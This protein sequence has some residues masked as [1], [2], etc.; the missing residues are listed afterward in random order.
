MNHVEVEGIGRRTSASLPSIPN[1]TSNGRYTLQH[2]PR[3]SLLLLLLPAGFVSA[4]SGCR[5]RGLCCGLSHPRSPK[6]VQ[7]ESTEDNTHSDAK[8]LGSRRV[9]AWTAY[10]YR[11]SA[12]GHT[13]NRLNISE[14]STLGLTS[15]GQLCACRLAYSRGMRS[16]NNNGSHTSAN[17]RSVLLMT[18]ADQC[19]KQGVHSSG[20]DLRRPRA[21]A[22]FRQ[23]PTRCKVVVPLLK[24]Q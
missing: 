1:S 22:F 16:Q 14:M 21:M 20:L 12:T 3:L 9:P 15:A 7:S 4:T 13:A 23:R 5:D 10:R 2:R 17:V 19:C 24:V 18:V 6:P 8:C 11:T